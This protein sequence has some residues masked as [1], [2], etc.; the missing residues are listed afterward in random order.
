MPNVGLM[1]KY[2][3]IDNPVVVTRIVFFFLFHVFYSKFKHYC[4]IE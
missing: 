1:K 3:P 2:G 4:C